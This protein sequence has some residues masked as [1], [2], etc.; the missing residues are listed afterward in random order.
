M[1]KDEERQLREKVKDYNSYAQV[2]LALGAYVYI[3]MMILGAGMDT[4]KWL[5]LLAVCIILFLLSFGFKNSSIRIYQQLEK[6]E[7]DQ[8]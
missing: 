3:G 1:N 8:Q 4:G 5:L 7:E 6:R 2:L